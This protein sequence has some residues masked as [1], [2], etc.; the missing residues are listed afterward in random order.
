MVLAEE[1]I[2]RFISRERAAR[3]VRRLWVAAI[4]LALSGA[5]LASLLR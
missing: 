1:E 4:A 3:R 5:G 2:E